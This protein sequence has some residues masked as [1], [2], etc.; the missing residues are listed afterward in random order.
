MQHKKKHV[1]FFENAILEKKQFL[2]E[3]NEV[4]YCVKTLR[5]G[6]NNRVTE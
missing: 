2:I 4:L 5:Q 1:T 6:I 3:E